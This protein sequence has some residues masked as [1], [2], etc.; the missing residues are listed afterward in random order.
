MED[1]MTVEAPFGSM[2]RFAMRFVVAP[3]MRRLLKRRAVHI[4]RQAE[5][6]T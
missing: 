3:Y 6:H 4:K 2:G 1:R 5:L